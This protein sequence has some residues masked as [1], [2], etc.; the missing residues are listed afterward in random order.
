MQL[1][2]FIKTIVLSLRAGLAT[3][4]TIAIPYSIRIGNTKLA[5][6]T[7]EKYTSLPFL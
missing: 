2:E 4:K 6:L 3:R 7:T 5:H 1:H